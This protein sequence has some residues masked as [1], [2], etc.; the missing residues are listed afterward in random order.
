M[1]AENEHKEGA[2]QGGADN[3][4]NSEKN[5]RRTFG[6]IVRKAAL[7]ARDT[8]K[9]GVE[10]IIKA[11]GIIRA[12]FEAAG[13]VEGIKTKCFVFA[14]EIKAGF[15]PDEDKSGVKKF[16]SRFIN[17]W[18]S[19]QS[20]RISI[21]AVAVVVVLI[22]ALALPWAD[23]DAGSMRGEI[24]RRYGIVVADMH[25]GMPIDEAHAIVSL[26]FD[27]E[28]ASAME[29]GADGG[30]TATVRQKED[31]HRLIETAPVVIINAAQNREVNH[32]IL[33]PDAVNHLFDAG[34]LPA[35]QFA[36]RLAGNLGITI[37]EPEPDEM[38]SLL[39]EILAGSTRGTSQASRLL[40][41]QDERGAQLVIMDNKELVLS[42]TGK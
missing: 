40:E 2:G 9:R 18:K 29:Q 37:P 24:H 7:M 15:V 30:W 23:S 21:V 19:G 4:D 10:L 38:D 16:G 28:W 39:D 20:G 31:A 26:R 33:T 5:F 41:Y 14:R 17:L 34:G 6:E 32:I 25:I 22:I 35:E 1:N 12:R 13:G 27:D 11:A 36:R 3:G 8:V 42:K